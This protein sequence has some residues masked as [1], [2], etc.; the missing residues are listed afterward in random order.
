MKRRL[1]I[2]L[3]LLG[4]LLT[5]LG[6]SLPWGSVGARQTLRQ[7]EHTLLFSEL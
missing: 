1:G 2:G 4:V 7:S 3:A 5:A 6:L